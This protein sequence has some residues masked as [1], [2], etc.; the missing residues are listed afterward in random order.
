MALF[1][2]ALTFFLALKLHQ[3]FSFDAH[4][5]LADFE[6]IIWNTLKGNF[7][8]MDVEGNSFFSQHFSPILLVLVPWYALFPSPLTLL[9]VQALAAALAIIPL[10]CLSIRVLQ[11]RWLPVTVCSIYFLSRVVNYGL[12]YDFHM[13]IF[14]PLIYFSLFWALEGKRWR[15]YYLFLLLSITV[16][17]D[18]NVANAGLGLFLIFQHERKHGVITL[19]VSITALIGI[20]AILIPFFRNEMN[21]T[22]YPFVGYWSGYG[23]SPSEILKNA[24]KPWRHF[25]VL[26]TPAKLKKMFNL[27]SVFLFLPLFSWRTTLFLVVPTWFILFSSDNPLLY[28]TSVYYGML[29]TPFLFYSFLLVLREIRT[30]WEKKGHQVT[31]CLVFLALLVNLGNSRLFLQLNPNFWHIDPR[32][33]TATQLIGQ[34]PPDA[35][36]A[37]QVDLKPHF[38]VRPHRYLIPSRLQEVEYLLFDTQGNTW[39]LSKSENA[40]LLEDLRISGQWD[41]MEE[42]SGFVLM[43]KEIETGNGHGNRLG[44]D[45]RNGHGDVDGDGDGDGHGHGHGYVNP[46]ALES[47]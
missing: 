21:Q 19:C 12:M 18:A 22:S 17:E 1:L 42:K 11:G 27:F 37:A 38:S 24:L 34:V 15:L 23:D 3:F 7:F 16:K 26:F 31:N 13:E 25:E 14:Y 35:S 36:V 28:G 5:E 43:R 30:R 44:N 41:V 29:I 8:V 4:S 45:H 2:L 6:T 9:T 39:P 10:Y 32:F 40:R 33:Q 46:R 47:D 20:M